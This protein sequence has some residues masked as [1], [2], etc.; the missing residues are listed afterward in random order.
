MWLDMFPAR[1]TKNY[2]C[3][4]RYLNAMKI[5]VLLLK[6]KKYRYNK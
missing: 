4:E 3:R 5:E 1:G 6:Q 2:F